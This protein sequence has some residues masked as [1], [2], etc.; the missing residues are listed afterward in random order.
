[1][2]TA[3]I[4]RFDFRGDIMMTLFRYLSISAILL[5]AWAAPARADGLRTEVE[6][7]VR[8]YLA[9]HPEEVQ[10]IVRSYLIANP[11]ILQDMLGALGKNPA[12]PQ[13]AQPRV[14]DG[15]DKAA[16]IRANSQ[17]LLRS[18]HQVTF[19]NPAGEVTMV[20]FFDYNC[21]YC[22]RA[23]SDM[24]DLMKD[25]PKL[26]VVL[27]ELPILGPGSIEAAKVAIAVRMQDTDGAKSL[28]FHRRLLG[29]R[30]QANKPAA[31][32]VAAELGLDMSK[33]ETDISS[34]EVRATLDES[35]RLARALGINGT[36]GYV[37]GDAIVAGAIGVVGLK[38]K[39]DIAQR[40]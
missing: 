19:G 21:G 4:N 30:T 12:T 11:A 22:K 8:D 7:V 5:T 10:K 32:A 20:E 1:M 6:A 33:L 27:K 37:I 26:K 24:V 34:D 36:P 9:S 14:A 39:I 25:N 31:L 18:S 40:Q 3:A 17:E 28:D 15:P 16:E 29:S 35:V 23:L 38:A 13:V 2:K